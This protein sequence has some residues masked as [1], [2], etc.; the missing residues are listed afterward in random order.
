[1]LTDN[2]PCGILRR[3]VLEAGVRLVRRGRLPRVDD[4]VYCTAEEL[5]DDPARRRRRPAPLCAAVRR[6][7]Q[8]W[9]RAHPGPALVGPAGDLP[10]LRYLPTHGR[11]MNEAVLWG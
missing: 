4:A 8:A 11:Q 9:V 10:D 1:M 6:N 2:V 5:A 3:W 7:E